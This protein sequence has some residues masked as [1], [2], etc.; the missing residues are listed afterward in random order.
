[1]DGFS[2][3]FTAQYRASLLEV[4]IRQVNL[5]D[6]V[7]DLPWQADLERSTLIFGLHRRFPAHLVGTA[8]TDGS[9]LWSW[10]NPH[11][12]LRTPEVAQRLRTEGMRRRIPE[13]DATH[14]VVTD[15][16]L[17]QIGVV[18]AGLLDASGYYAGHHEH[19]VALFALDDER[20]R[21]VTPDGLLRAITR[22]VETPVGAHRP[23]IESWLRSSGRTHVASGPNRLTVT[24]E[25]AQLFIEFDDHGRLTR[26][27]QH[28]DR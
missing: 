24:I 23:V 5:S 27:D 25:Q 8:A 17:H 13:L 20:L 10:H 26:V 9:F 11:V 22:L 6:E 15:D 7:G 28:D 18:A 12:E 21:R 16:G 2:Q 19:G 4:T 1:M 3:G 14:L